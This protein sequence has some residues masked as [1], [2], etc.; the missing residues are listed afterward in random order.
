MA[1]DTINELCYVQVDSGHGVSTNTFWVMALVAC[2]S[3]GTSAIPQVRLGPSQVDSDHGVS[4]RT[5]WT[6]NLCTILEVKLP[7]AGRFQSWGFNQHLLVYGLSY[8]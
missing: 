1:K 5:S 7:Y 8:P 2:K 3:M 4:T 6:M